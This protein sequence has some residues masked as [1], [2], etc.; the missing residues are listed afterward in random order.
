MIA[1]EKRLW[2][3]SPHSRLAGE[4]TLLRKPGDARPD[5]KADF[6]ICVGPYGARV[7]SASSAGSSPTSSLIFPHFSDPTRVSA[8]YFRRAW[9]ML[10][11]RLAYLESCGMTFVG[12]RPQ[13][14][15]QGSP[16]A[17]R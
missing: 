3:S 14:G 12:R 10:A 2:F 4:Q 17:S 6:L 16:N 13:H 15:E 11:G 8:T 7:M 5:C 1:L 9:V